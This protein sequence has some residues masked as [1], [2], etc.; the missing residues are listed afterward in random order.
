MELVKIVLIN[1][2]VSPRSR[3]ML[4]FMIDLAHQ[5]YSPLSGELQN[6]YVSQLGTQTFISIQRHSDLLTVNTK[7]K[8]QIG[9]TVENSEFGTRKPQRIS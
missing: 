4:L 6:F 5:R 1:R 9:G 2:S 8:L 3:G 7:P